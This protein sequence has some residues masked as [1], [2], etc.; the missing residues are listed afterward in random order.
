MT[1]LGEW[2]SLVPAADDPS[3]GSPTE[4]LLRL[5]LPLK[6]DPSRSCGTELAVVLSCRWTRV[7][8]T[9]GETP[10]LFGALR[11]LR[12]R[13]LSDG[14][15]ER[16]WAGRGACCGP[17]SASDSSAERPSFFGIHPPRFLA[18]LAG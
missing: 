5:L 3:A 6:V 9:P 12:A 7:G 2:C 1:F 14:A 8:A 18:G 16:A 4:T 17:G 11:A 15:F 10:G 13:A